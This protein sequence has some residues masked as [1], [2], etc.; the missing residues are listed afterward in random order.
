AGWGAASYAPRANLNPL[1]IE[2]A[3]TSEKNRQQ[4]TTPLGQL[5]LTTEV[6]NYPGWPAGHT[7]EFLKT[8]LPDE[9]QPY[10]VAANKPQPNHGI[11]GPE[12]MELM[13]QQSKNFGSRVESKDV[14]K[15]NLS[16]RPFPLTT[17]NGEQVQAESLII[18]TA[19]R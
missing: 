9:H 15:V 11:N 5:A 6:E 14:V 8:A 16:K 3:P 12:L 2:G 10:W 19:A 4:G 7:R 1:V 13:R 17:H 18:P